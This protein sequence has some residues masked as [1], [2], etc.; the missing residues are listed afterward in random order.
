MLTSIEGGRD[1]DLE[2]MRINDTTW[3]VRRKERKTVRQAQ[4]T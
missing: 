3:L 2:H 4:T 1:G